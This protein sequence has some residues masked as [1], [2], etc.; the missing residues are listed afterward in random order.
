MPESATEVHVFPSQALL[1][2]ALQSVFSDPD[3]CLFESR[4]W[5]RNFELTGIAPGC[6]IRLYAMTSTDDAGQVLVP[7]VYSRLFAAHGRSKVL[8]FFGAEGTPYAPWPT[9]SPR[10]ALAAVGRM[11]DFLH[12]N[13]TGYDVLRF[14]PL[15]PH[16][17]VLEQ[18]VGALRRTGHPTQVYEGHPA[19][20]ASTAT[21][22]FEEYLAARPRAFRASLERARRSLED[23][24]RASFRLIADEKEIGAAAR[25]YARIEERGGSADPSETPKYLRGLM[26][27]AARSG[28]LRIGFLD[29]DGVPAAAQAWVISSN[30][31]HCLRIVSIDSPETM[32]LDDLLTARLAR[33]LIDVDRVAELDYGTVTADYGSNWASGTRR[34]VGVVAFNPRT[35]RGIKGVARHMALPGMLS[36]PRRLIRKTSGRRT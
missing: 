32:L 5:L 3:K 8:H 14:S 1:P 31:A 15:E 27:V 29:V 20:F 22:T 26:S 21:L 36:I 35:W 18:V 23:A 10:D 7:A 28:V 30:V 11:I 12:A 19:S 13:R 24:G 9:R 2:Q 6:R 25:D 34:R 17:P 4:E 16:S 33:R